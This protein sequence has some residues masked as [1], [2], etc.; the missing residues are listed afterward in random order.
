[1]ILLHFQG[2][3]LIFRKA[4]KVP[5]SSHLK[6]TRQDLDLQSESDFRIIVGVAEKLRPGFSQS[7]L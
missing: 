6:Q 2:I 7:L 3:A 4:G 5:L 1:M